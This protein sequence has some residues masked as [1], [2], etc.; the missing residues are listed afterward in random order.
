[1][2]K[3]ELLER[4][5]DIRDGIEE[6][7]DDAESIDVEEIAVDVA[8]QKQGWWFRCSEWGDLPVWRNRIERQVVQT[9]YQSNESD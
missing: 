1:M 5:N 7:A 9:G 8:F 3:E 4:I 2:T 6:L